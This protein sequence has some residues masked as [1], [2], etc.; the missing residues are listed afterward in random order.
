LPYKIRAFYKFRPQQMAQNITI[1]DFSK[2]LFWDVDINTF[3]FELHKSHLTQK[4]LEYGMM[5]DWEL[6]K[7]VY[8]LETIKEISL[9]LRS[10]DVVTLSFLSAIFNIDK[11]E[12]RCYKHSLLFPNLWNS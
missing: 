3:D 10:L 8:G 1:H 5:K 11:S 6:L 2:H 4:V 12:F 9:N 7:K